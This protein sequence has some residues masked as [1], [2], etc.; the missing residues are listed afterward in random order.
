MTDEQTAATR[1]G[2]AGRVT[3]PAELRRDLNLSPGDYVVLDV[4]PLN[5]REVP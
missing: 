2:A 3:L 1:V 5:R 4:E